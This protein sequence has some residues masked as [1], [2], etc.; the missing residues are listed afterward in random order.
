MLGEYAKK[1]QEFFEVNEITRKVVEPL[2]EGAVAWVEIEGDP[3]P[4]TLI[5]KGGRSYIIEGK[6]EKPE[7]YFKFSKEAIDYLL[8]LKSEKIEDYVDRLSECLLN[9][10]PTRWIKF[11][12]LTTM[13]D[14]AR[15]GYV[16]MVM[17]GG[18]KALK[19][20]TLLGIRIPKKLLKI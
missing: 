11:N 13:L 2:K 7:V 14:A 18:K 3:Q 1:I 8:S 19:T 20:L 16:K 9:P 5:K 15:K 12:L 10:T 4:Y 17:L 6:P